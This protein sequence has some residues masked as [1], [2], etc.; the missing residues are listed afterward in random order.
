MINK[1][2]KHGLNYSPKQLSV[3]S[4]ASDTILLSKDSERETVVVLG[5]G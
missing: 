1:D 4:G 5:R 3:F 2:G